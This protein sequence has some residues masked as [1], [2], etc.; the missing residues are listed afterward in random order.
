MQ[1]SAYL[2]T[3]WTYSRLSWTPSDYD[4]IKAIYL[5]F[6]QLWKPDLYIIN[7]ADSSGYIKFSETTLAKV[8]FDCAKVAYIELPSKLGIVII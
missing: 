4:D 8:S 1:S 2:L 5:P 3:A 7:S 6:T